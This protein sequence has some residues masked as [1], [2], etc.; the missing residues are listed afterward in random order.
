MFRKIVFVTM[1]LAGLASVRGDCQNPK[2][3]EYRCTHFLIYYKNV[4]MDFVKEVEEAAEGYYSAITR[5]LGF[6]RYQGWAFEGR[7]KIF[8]YDDQDDY[9][10]SSRQAGWSSGMASAREKV[11]RTFPSAH[12]FFDS[13]LP[14]EL[15]HIIFREFIGYRAMI[16]LW[17]E[18][19]VAMHQ[20]KAKR[21]GAHQMVLKAIEKGEFIPLKAL[22]QISLTQ[23]TDRATVDLFYTESA[24][25]VYYL[26]TEFGI[27][28]FV[29]FCRALKEGRTFEAAFVSAYSR[30]QNVDDLNKAWVDYLKRK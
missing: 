20:E 9:V 22:T 18:E 7:A 23:D 29:N 16:P 21:W 30:F 25:V 6:T 2:W 27:H 12:G 19:G 11:I 28:R 13:T 10:E 8:I 24:S 14:H 26:I 17:L 4:P 5:N 15:G 1:L 3:Q